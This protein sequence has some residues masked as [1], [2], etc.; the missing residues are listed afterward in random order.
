MTRKAQAQA[1]GSTISK[2]AIEYKDLAKLMA[3][4]QSSETIETEGEGHCLFFQTFMATA[5]TLW[6]TFEELTQLQGKHIKFLEPSSEGSPYFTISVPFRTSNCLDPSQENVYEI[7]LQSNEPAACLVTM[8]VDW[9]QW[10]VQHNIRPL[11]DDDFLFPDIFSDND[12]GDTAIQL[13]KRCSVTQVTP[14]MDKYARDTGLIEPGTRLSTD[15]LR[16]GGAQHRLV[17]DR[18]PFKAVKWWGGW[19]DK[20]SAEDVL[21]YILDDSPRNEFGDMMSPQRSQH[22]G[23]D[24]MWQTV[25]ALLMGDRFKM[26]IQTTE[27]NNKAVAKL[28]MVSQ[29]SSRKIDQGFKELRREWAEVKDTV[30]KLMLNLASG[31]DH[32]ND[33]DNNSNNDN[34][35]NNNNNNF[36]QKP[37]LPKIRH[38]KEAIRQWDEGDPKRGLVVPLG[39][40]PGVWRRGNPSFYNRTVIVQ[41]FEH[42]GRDESKMRAEYG[43]LLS[44][45]VTDLASA[46]REKRKERQIQQRGVSPTHTRPGRKLKRKVEEVKS[47]GEEEEEGEKRGEEDDEYDTAE[48]EGSEEP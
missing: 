26:A 8:L 6:L 19:S 42:F 25:D 40:W 9:F 22:T 46:I 48:E 44:G 1:S 35:D 43:D 33:A 7:Y 4:L 5:F 32:S 15:C 23:R 21:K 17:H 47:E 31:A 41:E 12:D 30:S 29:Q 34:N 27:T 16:R 20:D 38:W 2:T 13:D 10:V 36:I 45:R 37:D 18:W 28:E 24:T 14:L 11:Q 3:H 39:K